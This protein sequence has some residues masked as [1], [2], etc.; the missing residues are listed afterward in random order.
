MSAQKKLIAK[1][2]DLD[3]AEKLVGAG[4]LTPK[5]IKSATKKSIKDITGLS[6]SGV[7]ELK[8]KFERK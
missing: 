2:V 4:L 5:S 8:A 3:I 6:D 7:D 1:S